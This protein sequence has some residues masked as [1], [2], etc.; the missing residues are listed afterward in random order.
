VALVFTP[1]RRWV[2]QRIAAGRGSSNAVGT[3]LAVQGVEARST[4]DRV[5]SWSLA[6]RDS[7]RSLDIAASIRFDSLSRSSLASP[8]RESSRSLDRHRTWSIA[9][10]R[11]LRPGERRRVRSLDIATTT[12][13]AR[14]SCAYDRRRVLRTAVASAAHSSIGR[15]VESTGVSCEFRMIRFRSIVRALQTAI[16][17]G[18]AFVRSSVRALRIA[19]CVRAFERM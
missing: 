16:A 1:R 19:M 15:A 3:G 6:N 5:P 8:G 12:I 18:Q 10:R 13:D 9:D 17:F 7:I 2:D 14:T 4:L 11:S